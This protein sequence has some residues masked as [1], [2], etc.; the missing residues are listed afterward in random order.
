MTSRNLTEAAVSS[1]DDKHGT[2]RLAP[3]R[4]GP[5]DHSSPVMQAVAEK[6]TD[7]A[8]NISG[9]PLHALTVHFPIAL[10]F[11][12]LG[13]DVFYWWSGDPFW[14]R[15]GLWAAGVAFLS[16]IAAALIGTFEILFAKGIRVRASSWNHAVSAM[17]L[18]AVAGTNWGL[19]LHAVDIG[20]VVLPHGLL[21]SVLAAIM[22]GFAGWHGGTLVY[23]HGVG[24]VRSP[25]R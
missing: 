6:P 13:A 5:P 16:G 4:E 12:T 25:G 15:A 2:G 20:Q 24:L 17:T 23:H 14:L 19:R 3:D 1:D 21:L 18:L 22:T 10:V 7:S 11:A 8:V 9:H